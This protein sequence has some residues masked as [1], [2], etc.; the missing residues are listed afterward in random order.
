[1]GKQLLERPEDFLS[2]LRYASVVIPL[3]LA[4]GTVIRIVQR[5]MFA[6]PQPVCVSGNDSDRGRLGHTANLAR[7]AGGRGEA[8]P[9]F[10]WSLAVWC[11]ALMLAPFVVSWAVGALWPN[12]VALMDNRR[13]IEDRLSTR[14]NDP[15]VWAELKRRLSAGDLSK[16]EIDDVLRE[17]IQYTD[18]MGPGSWDR[19]IAD[20]TM[21][22]N[23]TWQ[24]KMISDETLFDL[25]DTVCRTRADSPDTEPGRIVIKE[26]KQPFRLDF[27][28][29]NHW[30]QGLKL[31]V[32]MVCDVKEVQVAGLSRQPARGR[33]RGD[34]RTR[35]RLR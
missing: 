9:I 17:L 7:R 3:G 35:V 27:R 11:V 28:F 15:A 33:A 5:A 2:T 21:F 6:S 22:I 25:C 32:Q 12:P 14:M 10:S 18:K 23:A 30:A 19:L 4:I 34:D 29:G 16:Q 24:A 26:F 31:P 8:Q 13:L 20:R 1:L